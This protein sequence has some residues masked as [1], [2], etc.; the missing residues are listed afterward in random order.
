MSTHPIVNLRVLKNRSLA[1]GS[2]FGLV[3]G[4][5][6]YAVLF[7]LPVFLQNMQ[8]Y[9]AY[10]TGMALLPSALISMVSFRRRRAAGP[11]AGP[12]RPAGSRGRAVHAA[13][14]A[15]RH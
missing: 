10:Q 2:L 9:T 7:L 1:A 5:G 6:L 8:G 14:T 3:L 13:P 15:C 11:E 4:L 12:A